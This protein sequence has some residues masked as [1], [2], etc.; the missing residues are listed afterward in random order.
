MVQT[1]CNNCNAVTSRGNNSLHFI[2]PNNA[3]ILGW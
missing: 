3:K 1:N 2:I